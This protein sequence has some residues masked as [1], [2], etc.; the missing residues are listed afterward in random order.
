VRL[1]GEQGQKSIG[2]TSVAVIGSS[3]LATEILK[4]LIL[5]GIGSYKIFDDELVQES[6]TGNNFFV[7]QDDL[8]KPRAEVVTA[9]LNV[10][11]NL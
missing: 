2:Q 1:W 10:S 6:D 11:E 4:S 8:K 9:N 7:S 5:A 3:A